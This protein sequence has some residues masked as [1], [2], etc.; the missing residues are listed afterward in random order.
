M[1]TPE[2]QNYINQARTNGMSDA[3]IREN[4]RSGGG[5]G[6]GDV[7]Q[8][9]GANPQ[10]AEPAPAAPAGG[11]KKN[12]KKLILIVIGGLLLAAALFF[13]YRYFSAKTTQSTY[14]SVT[15]KN[16]VIPGGETTPPSETLVSIDPGTCLYEALPEY[17]GAKKA[18]GS[19]KGAALIGACG[20]MYHATDGPKAVA[21][22]YLSSTGEI[23]IVHFNEMPS[24]YKLY[25]RIFD[26]TAPG[27]P[28]Q[29]DTKYVPYATLIAM[30]KDRIAFI[31]IATVP[32]TDSATPNTTRTEIFILE[33]K[34]E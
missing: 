25:Y 23:D 7:D 21:D 10:P 17:P 28:R 2:L 22:Y 15:D 3:Q 5:W 13:G 6:E 12:R 27:N 9:L 29:A 31:Q 19:E 26:N 20:V 14:N 1:I 24:A 8:A 11:N 34:R 32:E 16:A 18:E 4:L 30:T 33:K